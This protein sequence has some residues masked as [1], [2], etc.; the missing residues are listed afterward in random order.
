[1]AKTAALLCTLLLG[2]CASV[3][4]GRDFDLPAFA[5]KV[6]RG[7]TTAHEVHTWLGEPA[8][9]GV[10]MESSGERHEQWT[11]YHGAGR[12]PGLSDAR[13][14]ILQVKFDERGVVHTYIFSIP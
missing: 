5:S 13:L 12:L 2:A 8:G 3:E 10:S 9:V 1:M 4:V 7:V 14:K 6:Q 11:Y